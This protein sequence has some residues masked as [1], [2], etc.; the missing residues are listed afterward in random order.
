MSLILDALNKSDQDRAEPDSIAGLQTLPGPAP[1]EQLGDWRPWSLAIGILALLAAIAWLWPERPTEAVPPVVSAA[2][3][4]EAEGGAEQVP[5]ANE[6]HIELPRQA[7]VAAS[8]PVVTAGAADE[9]IA[10]LYQSATPPPGLDTG[11]APAAA[12]HSATAP[13]TRLATRDNQSSPAVLDVDA[14]ARAAEQALSERPV[15][16]HAVPLINELNQRSKDEIPSVFFNSH[17]WSPN[18]RERVVVLN[19]TPRREGETVK[20]GLTLVEILEDSI[21]LDYRGTEFRL[22]SLNSWVNL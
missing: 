7:L 4:A 11:S 1:G 3:P 19:G 10:A 16:E 22:R 17:R 15:V 6:V 8:E 21:V 2:A 9:D 18:P 14:L 13:G 5:A 20:P 12:T